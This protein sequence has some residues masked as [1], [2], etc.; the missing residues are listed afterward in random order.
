M[1]ETRETHKGR[2]VVGV[3]GSDS[4]LEALQWA[5]DYT[6]AVGG[7]LVVVSTWEPPTSYGFYLAA[8][9]VDLDATTL[10]VA[11]DQV[12]KALAGHPGLPVTI[13]V[14]RGPA[15]LLLVAESRDADLLVVGSR[16]RG[17]FAGLL[18]G[19]VSTHCIHHAA[20]PVVV[21]R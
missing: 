18:L 5:A 3:D 1:T 11:E 16:G 21:C 10:A 4:A 2:V 15:A 17:G 13:K 12:T 9:S 14:E 6:S 8:E 19:S 20:C 7:E